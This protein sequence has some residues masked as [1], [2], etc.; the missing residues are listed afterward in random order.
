MLRTIA[1]PD[2]SIILP[3]VVITENDTAGGWYVEPEKAEIVIDGRYY[4]LDRGLIAIS[5][6]QES[7]DNTLAHEYRHHW[8]YMNGFALDSIGWNISGTYKE[9]IIKYFTKSRSEMDAFLFAMA[10]EAGDSI[11][12]W[13]EWLIKERER[14]S[15][16]RRAAN[17]TAQAEAYLRG[18]K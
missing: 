4:P 16:G 14:L 11:L 18:K 12:E 7:M 3:P 5:S 8:Q 2:K 15:L 9:K 6:A 10:Y 17:I 1:R 13:Q